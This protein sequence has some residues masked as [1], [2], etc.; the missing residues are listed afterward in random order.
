MKVQP[1]TRLSVLCAMLAGMTLATAC[2]PLTPPPPTPAPTAAATEEPAEI[3]P[4]PATDE[5]PVTPAATGLAP[6]SL[7]IPA[8]AL[9][10]P[11]E[12]MGWEAVNVGDQRTTRWLLPAEAAGWAL[13]SAGAGAAG[14]A[15]LA[16]HQAAGAALFAPLALGEVEV[17]QEIVLTDEA[18]ATFTYRVAEV[19]EPIPLLGATA[20]E[21]AAAAAYM[22]PTDDARLTLVTGW[23]AA[24]TTHRIFAVAELVAGAQ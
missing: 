1:I 16:G 8:L 5:L 19:S 6:V 13:N 3:T 20:D 2:Q 18:G 7:A 4:T 21:I 17:D 23:P 15:V 24:T 11:V 14:N 9:E 12:P 10:I 22:A